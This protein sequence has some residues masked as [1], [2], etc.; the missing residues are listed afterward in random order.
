[1]VHSLGCRNDKLC[2]AFRFPFCFRFCRWGSCFWHKRVGAFCYTLFTTRRPPPTHRT[3]RRGWLTSCEQAVTAEPPPSV[4]LAPLFFQ[5]LWE[6]GAKLEIGLK[7]LYSSRDQVSD[8]LCRA[9][10]AN[11]KGLRFKEITSW[12]IFVRVGGREETQKLTGDRI[13]LTRLIGKQAHYQ[14]Y[15]IGWNRRK[16][17]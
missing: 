12:T 15:W 1:M 8:F 10:G 13:K 14:R 6:S 2:F 3:S 5:W 16:S 9:C 17:C 7:F 4:L 11:N